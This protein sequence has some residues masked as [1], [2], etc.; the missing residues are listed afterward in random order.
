MTLPLSCAAT[1]LEVPSL[2]MTWSC[3][4]EY[5]TLSS[6]VPL[7]TVGG[8][9]SMIVKFVRLFPVWEGIKVFTNREVPI[10]ARA[11]TTA[12]IP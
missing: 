2:V 6:V 1:Q 8:S 3:M 11:T 7:G 10:I 5:V 4:L 12:A 9:V